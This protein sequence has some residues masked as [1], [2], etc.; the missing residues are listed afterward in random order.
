VSELSPAPRSG[1][2]PS[3][4]SREQRA[5]R[6]VQAGGVAAVVAVVGFVLAVVGVIGFGL[7]VLAAV[8]A[9]VCGVLFRRTVGR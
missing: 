3:R 4:R 9:V 6:L 5:Y 7:A 8:I 2:P 1:R